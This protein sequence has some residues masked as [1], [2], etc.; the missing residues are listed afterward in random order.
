MV[1]LNDR[2]STAAY[3]GST[4]TATLPTDVDVSGAVAAKDIMTFGGGSIGRQFFDPVEGFKVEVEDV[5]EGY[6]HITSLYE[7][8]S[9]NEYA[10]NL[11][12]IKKYGEWSGTMSRSTNKQ[13]IQAAV[14]S[15]INVASMFIF[16]QATGAKL[17]GAGALKET[18]GFA[19][20]GSA[21]GGGFVAA[22]ELGKAQSI[23]L[24]V[25]VREAAENIASGIAFGAGIASTLKL[26]MLGVEHYAKNAH[27]K[28]IMATLDLDTIALAQERYKNNGPLGQLERAVSEDA[29]NN[30]II[31]QYQSA[32]VAPPLVYKF[33]ASTKQELAAYHQTFSRKIVGTQDTLSRFEE[34]LA[35][36]GQV[37]DRSGKVHNAASANRIINGLTSARDD[38]IIMLNRVKDENAARI[39]SEA[40]VNG[41]FDPWNITKNLFTDSSLFKIFASPMVDIM[42]AKGAST[43]HNI[44]KK[45]ALTL[46]G[47]YDF[48]TNAVKAKIPTPESVF[49]ASNVDR[50]DLMKLHTVMQE[51]YAAG[52]ATSPNRY[53]GLRSPS[54]AIGS[55]AGGT[56]TSL[57]WAARVN[58]NRVL[59]RPHANIHEQRFADE[60]TQWLSNWND[61]L[62][63]GGQIGQVASFENKILVSRA[64]LETIEDKL[65]R[66]I[67]NE[68]R[69]YY[70]TEKTR[71]TQLIKELE[72]EIA[73]R[74]L[75]KSLPPPSTEPFFTRIFDR[76]K[77][78]ANPLT[79]Q[80]ILSREFLA[81]GQASIYNVA[82]NKW[83]LVKI[84][85]SPWAANKAA[86][87]WI[88][89]YLLDND[90]MGPNT[91]A[92]LSKSNAYAHRRLHIDNSKIWDFLVTDPM[93]VAKIYQ[94]RVSPKYHYNKLHDG[95]S[96][97]EVWSDVERQ[98]ID[99]GVSMK[100]VNRLGLNYKLLYDRIVGVVI[101]DPSA[102]NQTIANGLRRWTSF[103]M[104]GS[105]GIMATME[106]G[107]ILAR[108]KLGDNIKILG[109]S[110]DP[111]LRRHKSILREQ[112][113]EPFEITL[114]AIAMRLGEDMNHRL[115]NNTLEKA[116]NLFFIGNL[117][118]PVTEGLKVFEGIAR[119]N[120]L[121]T[122]AKNIA[123]KTVTEFSLDEWTRF[124]LSIEDAKIISKMPVT[125]KNSIQMTDLKDWARNGVDSEVI[126][127]WRVAINQSVAETIITGG[128][129][130]RPK[131][132]D[133]VSYIRR[134]VANKIPFLRNVPDDPVYKGYIRYENGLITPMFQFMN[135]SF[136]S[137]NRIQANVAHGLMRNRL[138]GVVTMIGMG[139]IVAQ[140]KTP[141]F[142]WDKMDDTEKFTRAVEIS[143]V[144]G[145]YGDLTFKAIQLAQEVGADTTALPIQPRFRNEAGALS[146]IETIG[147]PA[148]S[149]LANT[150][151]AIQSF[152]DEGF[153]VGIANTLKVMGGT[154]ALAWSWPMGLID[155][156]LRK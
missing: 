117:L 128:A 76:A 93:L 152:R 23:G 115:V 105:S 151:R 8:Q 40:T 43:G 14:F 89:N 68:Q 42:Q 156:A 86:K 36:T 61:K 24:P 50:G 113:G 33:A 130:D 70:T 80:G 66:N 71:Y 13:S 110:L 131:I 47:G 142:V 34:E 139:Y 137:L 121:L 64:T 103:A 69:S 18:L 96:V 54:N 114:G 21:F 148:V 10:Y 53:F 74:D 141:G 78:E 2:A 22:D 79:L 134:D 62:V 4:P 147:G 72:D 27:Q 108:H 106:V 102:M 84:N 31:L 9:P 150:G 49:G 146:A 28:N 6:R 122:T 140:I 60:Y 75:A 51:A 56:E 85:N 73:A 44:L 37:V 111:T 129:R 143:G 57:Q 32:G 29:I 25:N 52:T 48:M 153:S 20:V 77:I 45:L 11:E 123:N 144:I 104:L 5:P 63:L 112:Y 3:F 12:L 135:W 97:S 88:D 124:G 126:S 109:L 35:R 81:N 55:F 58:T 41:V 145:L 136:G 120:D 133:G 94:H 46:G 82:L 101:R 107:A 16:P 1:D 138:S 87:K 154:Q 91:V 38:A 132:V 92:N 127:R 83:E 95:K 26:T 65:K 59:Q 17:Y 39:G 116:E 98:L 125:E 118:G 100:E 99:D 90:A 119:V 30:A 7:S 67:S 155:D 149:Q 15:P 19:T